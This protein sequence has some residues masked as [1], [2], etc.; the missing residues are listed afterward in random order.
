MFDFRDES[1]SENRFASRRANVRHEGVVIKHRAWW[2]VHNLVA[3]P[4][5]GILPVSWAFRFH[6]YT[7]RMMS[8]AK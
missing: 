8:G 5:I 1:G 2:L 3:H 6:D 4:L 7:S